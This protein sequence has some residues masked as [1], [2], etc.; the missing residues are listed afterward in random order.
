MRNDKKNYQA[1]Y[2][3]VAISIVAVLQTG[4]PLDG[5]GLMNFVL[6]IFFVFFSQS[7]LL[8]WF[9]PAK[10]IL[11]IVFTVHI[12]HVLLQPF[13]AATLRDNIIGRR[14]SSSIGQLFISTKLQNCETDTNLFMAT[15]LMS[16][17]KTAEFPLVWETKKRSFMRWIKMLFARKIPMPKHEIDRRYSVSNFKFVVKLWHGRFFA[18]VVQ[19]GKLSRFLQKNKQKT[20]ELSTENKKQCQPHKKELYKTYYNATTIQ[21]HL[22]ALN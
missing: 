17:K 9:D 19:N 13:R 4:A 12:S 20:I 16:I 6:K 7:N 18:K 15:A 3:P 21:M 11:L 8:F 10:L 14:I 22:D 1:E 2:M 5:S